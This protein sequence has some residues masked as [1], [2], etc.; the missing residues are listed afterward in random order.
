MF[1]RATITKASPAK[2]KPVTKAAPKPT[3]TEADLSNTPPLTISVT[4]MGKM[5]NI[6]RKTAYLLANEPG[7]PSLRV[8]RRLMVNYRALLQWVEDNT[9][10]EL[11]KD[12]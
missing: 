10:K 9:A 5:L 8:G 12:N 7:F 2:T 6:S 3:S 1:N 4:A 11:H